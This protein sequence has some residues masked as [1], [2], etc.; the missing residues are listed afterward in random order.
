M[1]ALWI[2]ETYGRSFPIQSGRLYVY[3]FIVF[4]GHYSAHSANIERVWS[5]RS[6]R[7]RLLCLTIT[8]TTTKQSKISN[9]IRANTHTLRSTLKH[10]HTFLSNYHLLAEPFLVCCWGHLCRRRRLHFTFEHFDVPQNICASAFTLS[11]VRVL[12]IYFNRVRVCI[13][14]MYTSIFAW[15][16]PAQIKCDIVCGALLLLPSARVCCLKHHRKLQAPH[17]TK[18]KTR[19]AVAV[20]AP[21]C[22]EWTT[23]HIQKYIRLQHSQQTKHS[24]R[25]TTDIV[26]RVQH[27]YSNRFNRLVPGKFTY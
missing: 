26:Q 13:W 5:W 21:S 2:S 10:A 18:Y 23:V 24:P 4:G 17:T 3:M 25:L 15:K 9:L 6:W 7:S 1:H 19:L 12:Y 16:V 27:T 14:C 22:T 20:V 11:V 8:N